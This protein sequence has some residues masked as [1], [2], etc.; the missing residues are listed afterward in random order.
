M[1]AYLGYLNGVL[2]MLAATIF[3]VF[4]YHKAVKTI[5]GS[6]S[7]NGK[8]FLASIVVVFF[9][10]WCGGGKASV[11]REAS[12][13]YDDWTCG[14]TWIMGSYNSSW[15]DLY[16]N[17]FVIFT[18]LPRYGTYGPFV[19]AFYDKMFIEPV[20]GAWDVIEFLRFG[21]P[22]NVKAH[23]LGLVLVLM[24]GFFVIT[25]QAHTLTHR[26]FAHRCFATSRVFTFLLACF[27]TL[28]MP[29]MWWSSLH[30]RH[31]RHSDEEGDPH[32]PALKGF[33]YAYAGWLMDRDN[34]KTR[35][36]YIR[37]WVT[38]YPELLLV[39]F[40]SRQIAYYVL[41]MFLYPV[42]PFVNWWLGTEVPRFVAVNSCCLG[43][44]LALHMGMSFNAYAH[45]WEL[46]HEQESHSADSDGNGPV[47]SH[48]SSVSLLSFNIGKTLLKSVTQPALATLEVSST[49]Q[50]SI[51]ES[52]NIG[53]FLDMIPS[54]TVIAKDM[55]LISFFSG[56]E[57]YHAR[58]HAHPRL[59]QNSPYWYED[60]VFWLIWT[61]EKSGA[62]WD[63][64]RL[65]A[66]ED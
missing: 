33:W 5:V 62:V 15:R 20:T 57:G 24:V 43:K 49:A 7:V 17:G 3:A 28:G 30:R 61:F 27:A 13:I 66:K 52:Q 16:I 64:Q 37:D 48:N 2:K 32:S 42:W 21:L 47:Q 35:L 60:W 44:I 36:S 41:Q 26:F 38:S 40:F 19:W 55:P 63:V 22:T 54:R 1:N 11:T 10:R 65:S 51:A 56:G 18:V 31:H 53:K 45:M 58:H 25:H 14:L 4:M 50:A 6:F 59:A 29:P 12:G 9:L 23:G 39:D 46:P 8:Y 34:W